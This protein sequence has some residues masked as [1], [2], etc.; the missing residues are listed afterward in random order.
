MG[1]YEFP[2]MV[3]LFFLCHVPEEFD[4]KDFEGC[5]LKYKEAKKLASLEI[6]ALY[7]AYI[8]ELKKRRK[9]K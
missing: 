9:E 1:T 4:N 6:G 7:N 3:C 5:N 2:Q 8:E